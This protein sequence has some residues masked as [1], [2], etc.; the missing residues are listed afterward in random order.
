MS[1][2]EGLDGAAPDASRDG[3]ADSLY[4]QGDFDHLRPGAGD[5]GDERRRDPRVELLTR[6]ELESR[7]LRI[8]RLWDWSAFGMAHDDDWC[9]DRCAADIVWSTFGPDAADAWE[10]L[11]EIRALLGERETQVWTS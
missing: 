7:K 6:E 10:E 9:C 11:Q 1:G 5:P 4:G 8:L 3:S 2:R